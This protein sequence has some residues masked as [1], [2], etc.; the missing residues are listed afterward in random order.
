MSVDVERTIGKIYELAEAE[1]FARM[2]Y[3]Y[4]G[5]FAAA[6]A[7]PVWMIKQYNA[8][9]DNVNADIVVVTEAVRKKAR[10]TLPQ[11]ILVP[12]LVLATAPQ[13]PEIAL[14]DE[15]LLG[16]DDLLAQ[17]IIRPALIPTEGA[18][19]TRGEL[20]GA[21]GNPAVIT[22]LTLIYRGMGG[23]IL[24]GAL[25]ISMPTIRSAVSDLTGVTEQRLNLQ[26]YRAQVAEKIEQIKQLNEWF[27]KNCGIAPG[28]SDIAKIQA[29]MAT[30]PRS[31][32]EGV[33]AP[34]Y[35]RGARDLGFWSW[36]GILTIVSGG[37]IAGVYFWRKGSASR[38][39]AKVA[40]EKA[41]MKAAE[42]ALNDERRKL[43]EYRKRAEQEAAAGR[44]AKDDAVA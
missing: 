4:L 10:P 38:T 41:R 32:R 29:C 7:L 2:W 18:A 13:Q 8:L 43:R 1:N 36:I 24:L 37:T 28:T 20:G 16:M 30:V 26:N 39:E 3:G 27:Q 23:G 14:A 31:L 33:R 42:D 35:G 34:S 25:A 5:G 9:V 11:P 22:P 17:H 21:L 40:A 19:D 12:R 15:T 6:K 44:A